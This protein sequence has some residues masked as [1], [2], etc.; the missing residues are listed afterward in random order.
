MLTKNISALSYSLITALVIT[1]CSN[2]GVLEQKINNLTTKVDNLSTKVDSLSTEVTGLNTQQEQSDK[3]V[4]RV[5]L[6]SKQ[7]AMD[8]K[9]ANDRITNMVK[10]YKK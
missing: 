10:S 5:N 1:G 9:R 4:T 6:A 7:A 8:A 2:T 3:M